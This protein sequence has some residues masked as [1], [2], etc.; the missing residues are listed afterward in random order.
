MYLKTHKA[1]KLKIYLKYFFIVYKTSIRWI[2]FIYF[3]F[4]S[5]FQM[6]SVKYSTKVLTYLT[7]HQRSG[8]S[9]IEERSLS[10]FL[11]RG[12]D[13]RLEDSLNLIYDKFNLQLYAYICGLKI[14]LIIDMIWNSH[15]R[16][17]ENKDVYFIVASTNYDF[18]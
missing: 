5:F 8:T 3:C 18:L 12:F 6:L 14:N 7:V 1:I 10:Y 11:L 9:M 17:N 2:I 4:F 15:L 16:T 13:F